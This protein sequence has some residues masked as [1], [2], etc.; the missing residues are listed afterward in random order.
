MKL[1]IIIPAYNEEEY[2]P[3]LLESIKNQDFDDYEVIVA[4]ADSDDNTRKIAEEYGCR[5]VDGGMPAVGRNRGAAAARG[6][7][8]LFLDADLVLTDGYLRDAVE[9]F[10]SEDLGIA[11]TQMIPI[12]TRRRDKILHE[13]ANRFM[14]LVE[15]I[16]PHGA[17][18]YGILTRRTSMRRWVA[19]MNPWTLGRTQTTLKDREDKQV[20]GPQETQGPGIHKE[21][22]K[23]GT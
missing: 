23:G 8:L 14:I 1:S 16:K 18:C 19:S 6:E 17:G 2:L 22:G 10:E 21:T 4:D 12:S 5:I 20:Q 11:I 7:L 13:F 9:E 3:G 15:S